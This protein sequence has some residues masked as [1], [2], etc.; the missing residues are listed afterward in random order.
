MADAP[1]QYRKH[2][3]SMRG[4]GPAAEAGDR[5]RSADAGRIH[6]H[7]RAGLARGRHCAA[8]QAVLFRTGSHSDLLEV[9][10]A[11]RKIRS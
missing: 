7:A 10:L 9:E 3:L 4:Q 8:P 5:G 1:R 2:L 11:K 6:L